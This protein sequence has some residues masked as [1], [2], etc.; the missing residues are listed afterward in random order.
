MN[1]LEPA[2]KLYAQELPANA[3]AVRPCSEDEIRL[4]EA[5]LA[6]KLPLAYRE[7]L[8]RMGHGGGGIWAGHL[9]ECEGLV[10][11]NRL[12]REFMV[13]SGSKQVL[14]EDAFVFHWDFGGAYYLFRL[15]EGDDP[16]VYYFVNPDIEA[17]IRDGFR[18]PHVPADDPFVLYAQGNLA[19]K[20][21]F[22]QSPHFSD[23]IFSEVGKF[24]VLEKD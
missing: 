10:E 2:R 21:F 17:S 7:F 11:A 9:W 14:P 5:E 15:G 3:S 23:F 22:L 18:L 20:D 19:G 8:L 4:V 12:A 6:A 1:Y 16:P 24:I 13:D